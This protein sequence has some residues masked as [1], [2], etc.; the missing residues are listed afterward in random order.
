MRDRVKEALEENLTVE[1][2]LENKI[3]E[4]YENLVWGFINEEKFVKMLFQAY[5]E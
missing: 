5:G 1:Q 4:G 2:A 3:T